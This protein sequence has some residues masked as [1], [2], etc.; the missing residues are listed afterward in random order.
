MEGSAARPLAARGQRGPRRQR[1]AAAGS[2]ACQGPGGGPAASVS[3]SALF[4]SSYFLLTIIHPD[5][6]TYLNFIYPNYVKP[7]IIMFINVYKDRQIFS[8]RTHAFYVNISTYFIL[9]YLYNILK[10]VSPTR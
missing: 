7:Q 3:F 2:V 10:P 4:F 8:T 9:V 5:L 6:L 1:S